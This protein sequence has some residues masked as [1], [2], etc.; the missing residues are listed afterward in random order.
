VEKAGWLRYTHS[1]QRI[2]ALTIL[3]LAVIFL[4]RKLRN[5]AR[6]LRAEKGTAGC[7]TGG[8]GCKKKPDIEVEV[9]KRS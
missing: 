6:D 3:L 2:I 4:L 9:I 7:G 5:I 1:M 8:C